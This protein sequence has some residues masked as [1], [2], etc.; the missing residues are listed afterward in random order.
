MLTPIELR[1]DL[2]QHPELALE[3]FRTTRILKDNISQL[4][5]HYNC[6]ECK[7]HS[8]LKTG[9]VVEYSPLPESDYILLRADLDA[10][11]LKEKTDWKYQSENDYMH[12]CGHDL[13]TSILYG[14]IKSVLQNEYEANLLFLFQP[15][16]E[17]KSG[18]KKILA[19][20]FLDEYEIKQAHALH[21]TDEY[22][23]GN[24]ATCPGIMFSSSTEINIDFK[25]KAAHIAFPENGSNA[26]NAL[27]LFINKSEKIIETYSQKIIFGIGKVKAGHTRNIV[28]D[29]AL[30]QGSL[31]T[32]ELSTAK[33]YISKLKKSLREIT[34]QTG[35]NFNLHIGS[36][37]KE[38]VNNNRLFGNY[39]TIL[40][41][42][43][44]FIHCDMKFT[45]EDFGYFSAKYP[46]LMF[47]LGTGSESQDN[48]YGL[49][50]PHF[51]PDDNIINTGINLYTEIIENHLKPA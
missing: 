11:P 7:I 1:H 47:W 15:A 28:P 49:H 38:V 31:R 32:K 4:I 36:Q 20:D 16:E 26:L 41:N 6:R 10:L 45:A 18:A 39:S 51:L 3:E 9:L 37:Y 48:N 2:H 43:F 25:G 17:A 19:K 40:S 8:P 24:I 5:N 35:V 12:A 22:L 29:E 46:S 42:S 14:T 34:K 13:H 33:S 27:R 21:V 30:L 50:N 23:Q 44:K